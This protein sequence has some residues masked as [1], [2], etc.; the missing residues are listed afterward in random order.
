M[1][2]KITKRDRFGIRYSIWRR[3]K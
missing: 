1:R 2:K 3:R